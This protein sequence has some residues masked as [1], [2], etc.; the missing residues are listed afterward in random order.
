M[1]WKYPANLQENTHAKVRFQNNF[2]GI[3]LQ[4]G[5]P[6]VNL[7][8]ILRTPF[9]RTPCPAAFLPVGMMICLIQKILA[10]NLFL[11]VLLIHNFQKNLPGDVS[12]KK[13]V[14]KN[15][16]KFIGKY[17]CHSH[18][19]NKVVTLWKRLQHRWFPV[20][21]AKVRGHLL[22]LEEHSVRLLVSV[23]K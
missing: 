6:P 19:F 1:F 12:Y 4:H 3:A 13:R 18:F 23:A 16:V 7:L 9:L 20:N 2:I 11:R 22:F 21:F 15:L 17:F 5:C 8:H 14:L 10:L